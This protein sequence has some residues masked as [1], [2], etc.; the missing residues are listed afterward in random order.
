MKKYYIAL[1]LIAASLAFSACSSDDDD[2]KNANI[3]QPTPVQKPTDWVLPQDLHYS[4]MSVTIDQ[5]AMP[6]GVTVNKDDLLGAFVD[7]ECR[8][9]ASPVSDIDGK[10]RFT[11]LVH[12]TERDA[13][14]E[15]IQVELK[16]YSAQKSFIYT[17]T[18]FPF[19]YNGILGSFNHSFE[20]SW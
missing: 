5:D 6:N 8:G 9:V 1:T 7:N 18:K 16:Y 13:N 2:N 15:N 19:E 10:Y 20:P 17:A 4:S 14:R 11:L 12:A 3:N